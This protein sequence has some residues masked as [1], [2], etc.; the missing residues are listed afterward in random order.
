M[1]QVNGQ[2]S[3]ANRFH[4]S[5]VQIPT[6]TALQMRLTPAQMSQE[7][8]KEQTGVVQIQTTMEHRIQKIPVLHYQELQQ[9]ISRHALTLMEM[10]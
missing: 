4:S 9:L 10:A 5:A 8:P 1:D 6:L 3:M 7:H 2:L